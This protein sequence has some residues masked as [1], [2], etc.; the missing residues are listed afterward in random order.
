MNQEIMFE[1]GED[2]P[3]FSGT[4]QVVH[5]APSVDRPVEQQDVMFACRLCLDSG[6]VKRNGYN[7]YCV[8]TA[9]ELQKRVDRI[10]SDAHEYLFEFSPVVARL[11]YEKFSEWLRQNQTR[12]FGSFIDAWGVYQSEKL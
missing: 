6:L 8:C 5:D 4:P 12:L 10:Q 2:L 3:I 11:L 9:G 1:N 7:T